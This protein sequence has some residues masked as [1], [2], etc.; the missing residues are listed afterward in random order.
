MTEAI[1]SNTPGR[2]RIDG[3][4]WQAVS[5]DAS[6]INVGTKVRVSG[7]DS[8]ILTVEREEE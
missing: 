3:D 4:N 5:A 2:V 8:I 6:P 7:Y 1:G